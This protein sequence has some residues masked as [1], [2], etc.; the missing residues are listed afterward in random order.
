M[1]TLV[2]VWHTT[3]ACPSERPG[4][5]ATSIG[6]YV[7]RFHAVRSTRTAT[8]NA[9]RFVMI[10]H[11]W[12]KSAIRGRTPTNT[13]IAMI[14]N[15]AIWT[16]FS[17]RR[18]AACARVGAGGA[19]VPPASPSLTPDILAGYRGRRRSLLLFAGSAFYTRT[20]VRFGSP[21]SP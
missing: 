5:A 21:G 20:P 2:E 14:G 4:I 9:D 16:I 11:T 15:S 3:A 1:A 13:T 18:R 17:T 10:A 19:G 12:S 7:T 8:S 6:Q